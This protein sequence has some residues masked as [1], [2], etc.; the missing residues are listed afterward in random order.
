[1]RLIF[2]NIYLFKGLLFLALFLVVGFG[3]PDK[4]KK[5]VD[6]IIKQTFKVETY[7]LKPINSFND[8]NT[9]VLK[10]DNFYAVKSNQKVLGYIILDD[11]KSKMRKFDYIVVLDDKLQII[12]AKILIYREDHGDEIS[13]KRWLRQ[14][15]GLTP[16]DKAVLG[17]NIDGISG[18]TISVRS[19][20]SEMNLILQDLKSLKEKS[21]IPL[22]H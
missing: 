7:K 18:A 8:K 12:N 2:K 19:M 10:P 5:K 1:M 6:K 11:A 9:A 3:V 21:V 17:K 20:T 13:S 22:K 16:N 4:L 14:F 15:F